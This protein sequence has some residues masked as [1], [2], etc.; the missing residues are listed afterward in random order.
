MG[1]LSVHI[2]E[3]VRNREVSVLE[4][5]PYQEVRLYL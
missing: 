3:T 2:Q 4:R 5:C 1:I